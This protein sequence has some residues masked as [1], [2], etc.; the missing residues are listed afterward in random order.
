MNQA[1]AEHSGA[2]LLTSAVRRRIV[3]LLSELPKLAVEGRPTRDVGLTAAEL[4]KVLDLHSTTVRFHLDRLV[5]AGLLASHFVRD[6]GA[7]RPKKK[8]VVVDG[9]PPQ[10]ALPPAEGPYQVLAA[11]LVEALDPGREG[12]Q[13][14]EEAGVEWVK[15]R[16]A[17][18]GARPTDRARTSGEWL[19]K[20]GQVV[21]L[22]EEWGYRPDVAVDGADGDVTFTLRDCPFLEVARTHPAVVCGVHRGLL[23]GAL[24]MA[25]E[26]RA[27]VSLRPFVEART[28][29]AV[30]LRD[31]GGSRVRGLDLPDDEHVSDDRDPDDR[32]PDDPDP[33]DPSDL[34][35]TEQESTP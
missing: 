17:E 34:T 14:P 12:R 28:C 26:D 7:G 8:Y 10:V 24:E 20:V 3:E 13:S 11:L 19:G 18:R 4:G 33:A 25:G 2:A 27:D 6:G 5:A 15:A 29:Q 22:L 21:D 32:D 23:K 30:V 35:P 31:A 16:L 9:Q 1:E